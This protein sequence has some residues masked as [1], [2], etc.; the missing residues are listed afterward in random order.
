VT[1]FKAFWVEKT[2][3]GVSHQVIDRRTDDLPEGDVLI[4]VA[5]SSVNY[6]DALSAKGMPGVTRNYPHTPGIDAAGTVVESSDP[7]FR[8]GDEVIVIGFDLGMNTPGGYGE[9]I[10]VPAGWVT[11]LPTG[12][13]L[14]ESMILGTAGLTAALCFD[15]LL[16]MGATPS[17]GPVVV[18]GA[19]GGVG[20]V[21]VSL[22]ASQG[23]EVVASSGKADRADYLAGLGASQVIGR[24][25]LSEENPRPLSAETW[26]HGIDTVGGDI[27]SNV[28]KSLKYGGSVAICGLVAS[29]AFSTTV[30]PFILR[31]VNVLGIDSVELPIEEKTRIWNLLARDWKLDNLE[32]MAVETGLDGLS[33]S[34]DTIFAGGVTGRTLVLH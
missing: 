22:L 34:I 23:F 18:T 7:S 11:P 1:D 21:A 25:E 8:E 3:D 13:S 6:K 20:S 17:D 24:D 14:R 12:L 29:P 26:A 30:L 31:G 5:C 33:E 32:E 27:L 16:R 4:K 2:D 10:R 15:K 28:I 19:T 9:Y